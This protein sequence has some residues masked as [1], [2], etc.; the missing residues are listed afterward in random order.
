MG[1]S[2]TKFEN[3]LWL[4]GSPCSGKTSISEILTRRFDLN[5]YHVDEALEKH[6]Q[7][8]DPKLQPALAKWSASSWEERWMQPVDDLLRDA[9]ACYR[10]HFALICEDILAMPEHQSLLVEGTAL[11][12]RDVA[13]VLPNK[14]QAIWIMP[15][16][17]FQ[18][19][20]YAQRPWVR[21]VVDQC[22][23]PEMAFNN[24]MERDAR[25]A[26]WIEAEVTARDLHLLKIDGTRTIEALT[27]VVAAQFELN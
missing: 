20:H 18:R 16:A 25:F 26:R 8:F 10:E 6:A 3:V 2:E 1:N 23:D 17:D 14:N 5:V 22:S 24:W 21:G 19:G 9:I 12:P 7:S 27:E 11:L 4:G 15:T 13:T